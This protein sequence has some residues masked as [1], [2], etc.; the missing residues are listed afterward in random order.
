MAFNVGQQDYGHWLLAQCL[1][2]DETL[3]QVMEREGRMFQRGEDKQTD[4]A[5][6]DENE[7][8]QQ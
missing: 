8:T 6:A 4:A 1:E 3:T 7:D 2:A 5:Q